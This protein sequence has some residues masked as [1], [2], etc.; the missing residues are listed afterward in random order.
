MRL[1]EACHHSPISLLTGP[2]PMTLGVPN[3]INVLLSEL[4]AHRDW[5]ALGVDLIQSPT[6]PTQKPLNSKFVFLAASAKNKFLEVGLQSLRVWQ[7]SFVGEVSLMTPGTVGR[8][9]FERVL[10]S[11]DL[12]SLNC[13]C[14]KEDTSKKHLVEV[15]TTTKSTS[16]RV[17]CLKAS[18]HNLK[19][20]THRRAGKRADHQGENP[21]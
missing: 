4:L 19:K 10:P 13:T 9:Q 5:F 11:R 12:P 6:L 15:P 1:H 21:K 17:A 3:S 16:K 20:Q 2:I 8:H 18:R 7:R 14:L